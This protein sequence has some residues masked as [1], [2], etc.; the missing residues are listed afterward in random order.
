MPL[1]WG[2]K[3]ATISKYNNIV[4]LCKQQQNLCGFRKIFS[5]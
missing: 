1:C 3:Q 4:D 5:S 2:I